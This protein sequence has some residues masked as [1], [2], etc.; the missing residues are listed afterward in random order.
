MYFINGH[1]CISSMVINVFHQWSSMVINSGPNYYFSLLNM[2]TILIPI[3]AYN[4]ENCHL[5]D[6]LQCSICRGELENPTTVRD[7]GHV[8]CYGCIEEWFREHQ[9]CPICQVKY[10]VPTD[11]DLIID[12]LNNICWSFH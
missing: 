8:F 6:D 5:D 4:G 7:C 12:I 3:G 1:Q 9:S 10:E 11:I 2:E